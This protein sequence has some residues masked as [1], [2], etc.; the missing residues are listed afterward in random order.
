MAF[1]AMRSASERLALSAWNGYIRCVEK[2][3][4]FTES[5]GVVCLPVLNEAIAKGCQLFLQHLRAEG[6]VWGKMRTFRSAF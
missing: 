4:T 2:A 5:H 3:I 6:L 1:S